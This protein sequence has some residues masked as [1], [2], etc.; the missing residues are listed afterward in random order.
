MT[1]LRPLFLFPSAENRGCFVLRRIAARKRQPSETQTRPASCLRLVPPDTLA[2]SRRGRTRAAVAQHAAA[3]LPPLAGRPSCPRQARDH[4][5]ERPHPGTRSGSIVPRQLL[6]QGHRLA[7]SAWPVPAG[8][9][10]RRALL[11]QPD[12]AGTASSHLPLPRCH[13]IAGARKPV[14]SGPQARLPEAGRLA[15]VASSLQTGDVAW[16]TQHRGEGRRRSDPVSV[17]RRGTAVSEPR[18]TR[19]P[20]ALADR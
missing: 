2:D 14:E 15:S 11:V 20:A 17:L 16:R 13:P 12:L 6:R 1:P 10:T 3:P 18:R 5:N 7:A 4:T 9:P 19:R 8:S